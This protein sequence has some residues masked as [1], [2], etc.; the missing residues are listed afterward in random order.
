MVPVER[1]GW[2][3]QSPGR[4]KPG[5][6]PAVI[7]DAFELIA[8]GSGVGQLLVKESEYN[9]AEPFG[10]VRVY[11]TLTFVALISACVFTLAGLDAFAIPFR[12]EYENP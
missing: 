4:K 8:K 6:S 11:T 3:G 5:K 2:T 10:A 12:A 1:G 9:P 7:W